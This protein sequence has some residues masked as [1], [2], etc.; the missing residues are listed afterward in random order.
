[1]QWTNHSV[2]SECRSPWGVSRR[3]PGG[4]KRVRRHIAKAIERFEEYNKFRDFGKFH[5][6]QAR[7]FKTRLLETTNAQTGRPLSAATIKSTLAALKAFFEWLAGQPGYKAAFS[8]GDWDYFSPS[9][10]KQ[11]WDAG[12]A[13]TRAVLERAPWVGEFDPLSG[14]IL[15]DQTDVLPVAAE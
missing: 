5:V 12:Y 15:H 11:R 14:V 2:A 9:G 7:G 8:F 10:I 6:E 4:G 13:H 3:H 1:M